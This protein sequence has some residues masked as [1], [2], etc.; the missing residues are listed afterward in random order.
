MRSLNRRSF[1]G[2]GA[3][4]PLRFFATSPAAQAPSPRLRFE[5]FRDTRSGF[6]WRL[7]GANGRIIA[8]SG[9]GYKT[10]AACLAGIVLVQRGAASAT[11]EDV[12]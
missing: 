5:V 10:K 4:L 8:D 12:A 3:T 7:K 6:R 2:L 11:I 9:E 1:V